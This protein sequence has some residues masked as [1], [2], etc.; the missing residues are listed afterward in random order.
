[1]Q[2][3]LP[4]CR[5]RLEH[6]LRANGNGLLFASFQ[7]CAWRLNCW[8]L[9]R[10]IALCCIAP[11]ILLITIYTPQADKESSNSILPEPSWSQ[12]W[13]STKFID[14]MP[15]KHLNSLASILL[16]L[17]S[18]FICWYRF[19]QTASCSKCI[20][21]FGLYDTKCHEKFF[22]SLSNYKHRL[23]ARQALSALPLFSVFIKDD[24]PF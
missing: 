1:M 12:F 3:I 22:F 16:S 18:I 6:C 8:R 5:R 4:C 20:N 13:I 7:A 19:G 17:Q 9:F 15:W 2:Q 21:D 23:P 11:Q 14:L 24:L 10:Q